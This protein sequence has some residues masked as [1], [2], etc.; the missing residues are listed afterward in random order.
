MALTPEEIGLILSLSTMTF[1]SL[2]ATLK[3]ALASNC[4]EYSCCGCSFKRK[5]KVPTDDANV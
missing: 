2:A 4:T 1:A 5:I 3:V